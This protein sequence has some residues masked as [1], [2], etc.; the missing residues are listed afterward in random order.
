MRLCFAFS[1]IATTLACGL[2]PFGTREARCELRPARGQCTDIRDFPGP[3]L[4]TF[5]GVCTT[6]TLAID[7]GVYQEN[8]RCDSAASLGGCQSA[9]IDG[10][11]Q[12]NWFYAPKYATTDEAKASCDDV[13]DYVAPGP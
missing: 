9:S 6:L 5:Q 4:I 3:S 2:S 8:A 11:K 12:T 7:G 1:V 10:T 13:N